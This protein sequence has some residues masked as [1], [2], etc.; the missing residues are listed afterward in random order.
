MFHV[1]QTGK[2]LI[3]LASLPSAKFLGLKTTESPEKT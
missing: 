1:K 2:L 3:F